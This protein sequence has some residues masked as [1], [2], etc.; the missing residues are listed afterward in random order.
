MIKLTREAI[1]SNDY[2]DMWIEARLEDD[3]NGRMKAAQMLPDYHR[4]IKDFPK[5]KKFSDAASWGKEIKNRL[6]NYLLE[7]EG[8]THSS[9]MYKKVFIDD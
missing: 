5:A 6:G 7:F 3:E 4:Y 9:A 2:I 1:I 8:K